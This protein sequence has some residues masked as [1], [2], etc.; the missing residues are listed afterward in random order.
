MRQR[1]KSIIK[2]FQRIINHVTDSARVTKYKDKLKFSK[3]QQLFEKTRSGHLGKVGIDQE[4]AYE[5][6]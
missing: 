3:E 4:E 2:L 6:Y 1:A 5:T